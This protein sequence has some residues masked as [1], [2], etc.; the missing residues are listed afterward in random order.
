MATT[1]AD[2][3]PAR[4]D[5]QELPSSDQELGI[6]PVD[7]AVTRD[8]PLTPR[9][10]VHMVA[11]VG[12]LTPDWVSSIEDGSHVSGSLIWEGTQIELCH[13]Y[14]RD[15][16]YEILESG[17]A[18]TFM[19]VGDIFSLSDG[20]GLCHRA[21]LESAWSEYGPPDEG[22]IMV[23]TPGVPDPISYC[24]QFETQDVLEGRG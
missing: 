1:P 7:W 9:G 12:P 16:T 2:T 24:G 23:S 10:S 17:S 4:A 3:E 14:V 8:V 22:C 6:T 20:T 18:S 13:L 5:S 11:E 21:A 19:Q 15:I